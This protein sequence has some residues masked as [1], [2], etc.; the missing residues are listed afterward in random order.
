MALGKAPNFSE[1]HS[2]RLQNGEV[3]L[4]EDTYV[5]GI[6]HSIHREEALVS[7][8]FSREKESSG[9]GGRDSQADSTLSTEPD[10]GL[11]LNPEVMT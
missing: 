5:P 9:G 10:A 6:Q 11:E 8:L 2:L 7:N 3:L 4:G 1:F